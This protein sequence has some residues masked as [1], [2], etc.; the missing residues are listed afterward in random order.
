MS[1]FDD[2]A[3]RAF[4]RGAAY[5]YAQVAA[6]LERRIRGGEWRF[7]AR[8]PS[9]DDLAAEYGVAERTIRRALQVLEADGL[10]TVV[11]A[12][13]VYVSWRVHG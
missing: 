8:L 5:A 7:D 13:G 1:E 3:P 2:E 11:P 12:K 9:R 6:D 10:V 4:S